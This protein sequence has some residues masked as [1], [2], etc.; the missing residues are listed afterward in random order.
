MKLFFTCLS[1]ILFF[2]NVSFSQCC[3]QNPIECEPSQCLIDSGVISAEGCEPVGSAYV[4]TTC[5]NSIER[6][7]SSAVQMNFLVHGLWENPFDYDTGANSL[8]NYCDDIKFLVESNAGLITQAAGIWGYNDEMD[9]TSTTKTY[10]N[11]VRQ[12]VCDINKAYDCNNLRRP[13][14]QASIFEYLDDDTWLGKELVEYVRIPQCVIEQYMFEDGFD[15]D[16]YC[17]DSDGDGFADIPLIARNDLNFNFDRIRYILDPDGNLTVPG[18]FFYTCPDITNFETSMWIYHNATVYMDC[19]I[20]SFHLGQI[21]KMCQRERNQEYPQLQVL[22]DKIREY[23]DDCNIGDILLTA[24][25]LFHNDGLGSK[26]YKE[27]NGVKHHFFDYNIFPV[28]FNEYTDQSF[29][30]YLGCDNPLDINSI[31]DSEACANVEG[32]A[33]I[34]VCILEKFLAFD[35]SGIGPNGCVYENMPISLY[36]DLGHACVDTMFSETP[37]PDFG[38]TW[39]YDDA[40]WFASLNETCK[41]ELFNRYFCNYSIGYY[42]S[43]K[44][45]IPIPGKLPTRE[46]CSGSNFYRINNDSIFK[47][48]VVNMLNPAVS[49]PS[50]QITCLTTDQCKKCGPPDIVSIIP[51]VFKYKYKQ[52]KVIILSVPADCTSKYSWHFQHESGNW[53][54]YQIGNIITFKPKYE[55]KYTVTLRIDNNRFPASDLGSKSKSFEINTLL[56]DCCEYSPKCDSRNP[57]FE[58]LIDCIDSTENLYL[59]DIQ[60]INPYRVNEVLV[61]A[62]SGEINDIEIDSI[63]NKIQLLFEARERDTFGAN[64]N[65]IDLDISYLGD[66]SIVERI[67]EYVD[68]CSIASDQ[69]KLIHRSKINFSLAPNPIENDVFF[70]NSNNP[71]LIVVSNITGQQIASF[72]SEFAFVD[73]PI[74]IFSSGLYFVSLIT[75]TNVVTHN[76]IVP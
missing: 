49:N 26:Y 9:P 75:E 22:L 16:Y 1:L 13:F 60:P 70:A 66:T 3:N 43:Q 68:P 53:E 12:M 51:K 64:L 14:V 34:D 58:V 37:D 20:N 50:Y 24:E 74:F 69:S 45:N 17:V 38:H 65:L 5:F 57:K 33:L 72:S 6:I 55:G 40:N 19:G 62:L 47:S 10:L 36:F 2:N 32:K 41:I 44:I 31:Y 52:N 63:D 48:T 39:G 29:V 21:G 56:T 46:P 7:L 35:Q 8:A 42:N 15:V 59:I 18:D 73:Y 28:W 61:R 25:P 11:S 76:I 71:G 30:D 23:A 67:A 27:E 4:E 54:K